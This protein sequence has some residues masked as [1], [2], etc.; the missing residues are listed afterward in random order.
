MA[1]LQGLAD[2]VG[3]TATPEESYRLAHALGQAHR[4]LGQVEQARAWHQRQL[5][6][7]KVAGHAEGEAV[8]HF[9]L[10]ELALVHNDY[11]AAADAARRGNE[12]ASGAPEQRQPALLG[13]GHRLVGAALAMEGSDLRAAE[14]HLRSAITAR[15]QADDSAN[16]SA[17]LF[18][19]GNVLAQQGEIR[20]A[21]HYYREAGAALREGEAPFLHA[22]AENNLAY[23]SLLL[24]RLD[25]ARA[26]L[27]RGRALAE[28]HGLSA[29]L[30]YLFSTESEIHLYTGG[31]AEAEAASLHGLALAE[32]CGNTERQAGY[33]ASLALVAAGRGLHQAAREQLELA[34]GMI[35]GG[36]YWHLRTR[37]L[38]WLGE[39]SLDLPSGAGAYLE[40]A[41][42]LARAQ[43]RRLI[44]LQAERLQALTLAGRDAA[45]AQAWLV[46]QL[47]HAAALDLSLEVARSRAALARVTLQ[48]AP[49]SASGRALLERALSE[50]V[51]HGAEAE[52]AALRAAGPLPAR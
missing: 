45:A 3:P 33:R 8:A 27:A 14:G 44:Q 12:R 13:R 15:R 9:E 47:D 40:T 28:G 26:A 7:A 50:L 32:R 25:D 37:L 34:L 46:E 11:G 20:Q 48:H 39:L 41:I 43:R 52:A 38:L 17:A 24:G 51:A 30:L 42:A 6:L 22:L 10:A 35:A 2:V 23:H 19:L 36:T 49:R 4:T 1:F 5:A 31:W 16:L 29:A 21:V 18:E